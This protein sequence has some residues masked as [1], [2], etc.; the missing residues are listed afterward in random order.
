MLMI[1][2][3]NQNQT[4]PTVQQSEVQKYN[5]KA[6]TPYLI[7]YNLIYGGLHKADLSEGLRNMY[8]QNKKPIKIF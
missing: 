5:T 8:R 3:K 1:K 7:F 6:I 2:E 4:K